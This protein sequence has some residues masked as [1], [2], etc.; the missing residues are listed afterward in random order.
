[1]HIRRVEIHNYRGIDDL[2]WV[3]PADQRF[4]CLIGPGDSAKSTILDAIN[5]A[6]TD[7]WSLA[8]ADT[9]FHNADVSEPIVIRVTLADL[10]DDVLRHDALGFHL[11]GITT[12][13]TLLR[14]PE[15]H[16]ETCVTVQLTVGADLDPQWSVYRVDD[17]ETPPPLRS[18]LRRKFS[19]F[20][21]DDRIDGHLRWTRTS[22]LGRLTEASHGAAGTLAHATRMSRM[23]VSESITDKM[24]VLT[25][26]VRD[27]AQ[28]IGGG[29]FSQLK[30]GLDTSL[31]ST[32]G[33]LALFN[34]DVPLTNYGLGSR[35]LTGLAA[36]EL[37]YEH[38]AIVL[39]DEIEYGLEPHRLVHLL[40]R[41]RNSGDVSQTVTTTHSPVAVEQLNAHDLAV[42]RFLRGKLKVYML[43][44]SEAIIQPMLRARPSVFLARKIVFGEGRTEYGLLRVLIAEWD[45]ERAPRGL[46]PAAALGVAIADAEGDTHASQRAVKMIEIGYETAILVDSDSPKA[47]PH[48]AAAKSAGV[49]VTQWAGDYCIESA[50]CADLDVNGLVK[51]IELG[52]ACRGSEATALDDLNAFHSGERLMTLDAAEM[53]TSATL[54]LS[55][56]RTVIATAAT[57]RKWFKSVTGGEMLG[58]LVWNVTGE[59]AST[60][61][62]AKLA[63]IKRSIYGDEPTSP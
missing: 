31:S 56:L 49:E 16:S 57:K 53:I 5:L 6:L 7:R 43:R 19:A 23:A 41:L 10:P 9:D 62:G 48:I 52:V 38:K 2:V 14:D 42:V 33:V 50:L 37:A 30:P 8:I 21:V 18:G 40:Y 24:Q 20:K 22:A 32:S 55:E 63:L 39:L 60:S 26:R 4:I 45:A 28:S 54:S 61:F 51:L 15:E 47:A 35:R 27:R 59:L 11:S 34:G 58:Q 3:I 17:Q 13:G 12:D 44:E 1:M 36:Q 46:P 25:D 29:S